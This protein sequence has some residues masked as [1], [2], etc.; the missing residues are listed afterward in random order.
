M[1]KHIVKCPKCG[2][3]FDTNEEQAVKVAAR[4]Y[5]HASCYPDI[6]DFV[7]MIVKEDKDPDLTAL[8][9]YISKI[10]GDKARWPLIMKQ[11][12][13]FKEKGYTTSGM[14]GTL[15]YFYEIKNGSINN[16]NGGIG[17]IEFTYEEARNFYE[18]IQQTQEANKGKTLLN[19]IKE[20][21][22]KPPKMRGLKQQFFD[23]GEF[24]DEE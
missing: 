7:P 13:T 23:L 19:E 20:I 16:T 3:S 2:K 14:L 8:K 9:N 22:I 18:N 10:Y 11:I 15:I 5:G 24:E 12:K 6:T 1:A 4:R 21:I 17:I